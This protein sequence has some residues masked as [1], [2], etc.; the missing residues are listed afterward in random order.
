M[1]LD[2]G[3]LANVDR[4]PFAEIQRREDWHAVQIPATAAKWSTWKRYC[5]VID[6]PIARAVAAL[7]DIELESVTDDEIET[8]CSYQGAAKTA[9]RE[10][11]RPG[12]TGEGD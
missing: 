5:Q 7:I 2:R 11:L 12:Q 9:R 4:R 6:L 3:K 8:S 10:D 1:A